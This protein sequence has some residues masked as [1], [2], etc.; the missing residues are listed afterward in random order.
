MAFSF[1][2]SL[3]L[4]H[5]KCGGT[6][7]SN[8]PIVFDT[9]NAAASVQTS[10]KSSPTGKIQS[11]S[12][13][14][15]YFYS[16]SALTTRL[17]AE[18]EV[19]NGSTG[20]GVW[21]VKVPTLSH[22]SDTV[23]YVAYGDATISS[24]P[25]ADATYGTAHV[26]DANYQSVLHLADGSSLN[27]FDSTS[28]GNS[29][30]NHSATATA[31]QIDGA[32]NFVASST[33][34]ISIGGL[35]NLAYGTGSIEWWQRP[36]SSYNDGVEHYVW[37]QIPSGAADEFSAQ[38]YSDNN[39]YIG[40]RANGT[41]YRLTPAATSATWLANTWAHFALTWTS[42][43]GTL[44]VN[45]SSIATNGGM[46]SK[47][48][49]DPIDLGVGGT[50]GVNAGSNLFFDGK[51][52]EFRISNTNRSGDWILSSYNNQSVPD[53]NNAGGFYTVGA[54]TTPG[55]S[56]RPLFL[57]HNMTGSGTGGSFFRSPE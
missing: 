17:A 16:D 31:G 36:T 6:D 52:D 47:N 14:D 53:K 40:W 19:W 35:T 1:Y 43:A 28:N 33:E 22:T 29:G 39:F 38:K 15:V 25:N 48:L 5:T 54:E 8:I 41:D 51:I 3:T 45:G 34:Y 50:F 4:D 57:N 7:S 9:T 44:Y 2:R 46:T 12:G 30:T 27:V 23:I 42:S 55:S 26:W 13:Y 18:R 24:D 49:G 20:V 56:T 10:F 21:W 37:G 11:G 32:A